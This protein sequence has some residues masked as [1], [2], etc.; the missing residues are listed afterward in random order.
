L[1]GVLTGPFTLMRS[2]VDSY[3]SDEKQIAF[4]FA[5]ALHKEAE[6]VQGVVDMISIDEPFFSNELPDYAIE[7]IGT[8]TKNISCPTVLHA[9]GDVSRIVSDFIDMPVDVLS[10]EFKASPQLFDAFKEFS[11]SK[12][13]CLGAVRSDDARV[14]PVKEIVNHVQRGVDVFGD[15]LI[16]ISPD[17]G[18]RLLPRKVAFDKLTNLVQAGDIVNG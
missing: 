7:L 18:Q 3:Y 14:E 6:K 5:Q 17:C 16:Q 13:M 4:D 15:K 1:K 12:Q 10:H 2:C 8:I 9:C 11:S